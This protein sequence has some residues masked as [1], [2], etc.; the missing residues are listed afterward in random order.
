MSKSTWTSAVCHELGRRGQLE[1]G[2][3]TG[4]KLGRH[5]NHRGAGRFNLGRDTVNSITESSYLSFESAG[6][7]RGRHRPGQC[8]GSLHVDDNAGAV[9]QSSTS[10]GTL[11][12]SRRPPQ[13]RRQRHAVGSRTR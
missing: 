10:G 11:T 4:R 3:Q 7:K 12:N 5:N 2:W 6:T 9:E 13:N 8:E 1:P